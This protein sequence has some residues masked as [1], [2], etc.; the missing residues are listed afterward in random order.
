MT[1]KYHNIL[2]NTAINCT[3]KNHTHTSPSLKSIS[4]F[5]E[6]SMLV[7]VHTHTM[8]NKQILYIVEHCLLVHLSSIL[9]LLVCNVFLLIHSLLNCSMQMRSNLRVGTVCAVSSDTLLSICAACRVALLNP[10]V[11][12]A[13]FSQYALPVKLS[14]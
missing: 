4:F 2:M 14:Y 3:K 12:A 5:L 7:L 6:L 8:Q 1:R 10:L 9:S 13:L 11:T